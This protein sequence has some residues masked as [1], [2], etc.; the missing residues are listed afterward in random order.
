MGAQGELVQNHGWGAL[1]WV[2]VDALVST[3]VGPQGLG[4]SVAPTEEAERAVG[5]PFFRSLG[6]HSFDRAVQVPPHTSASSLC[7]Y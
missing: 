3:G 1:L 6:V 2:D 7:S 4:S 5:P